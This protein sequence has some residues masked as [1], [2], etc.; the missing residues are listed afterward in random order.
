MIVHYTFIDS[1][2]VVLIQLPNPIKCLIGLY[3]GSGTA[4]WFRPFAITGAH[5]VSVK[6][7]VAMEC[8]QIVEDSNDNVVLGL[9]AEAMPNKG[10]IEAKSSPNQ[11]Q[12]KIK[13]MVNQGRINDC[14]GD[15]IAIARFLAIT[16]A[17]MSQF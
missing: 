8:S 13:L 16:T 10:Q 4:I 3:K 12:L 2:L 7:R 9:K 6:Y 1:L 15:D 11:G 14:R 5:I 17:E